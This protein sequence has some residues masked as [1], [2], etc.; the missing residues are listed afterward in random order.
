MNFRFHDL[1]HTYASQLVMLGI[2]IRTVQEL[3]GHKSIEMTL[4]YSHLSPP[5]KKHAVD[6]LG[7]Q[8]DT[9]WTPRTQRAGIGGTIDIHNI[10][11]NN[12]LNPSAP[13]AQKDR[14]SVS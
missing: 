9:I 3:M 5:H 8:M 2:D 12:E 11:Q 4:R 14:A 7:K 6:I 10:L 1:R 13:V